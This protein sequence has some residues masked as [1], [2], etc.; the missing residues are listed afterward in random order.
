MK[1]FCLTILWLFAFTGIFADFLAN[2]RDILQ[3]DQQGHWYFFPV[4]NVDSA[5]FSI[6][7]L[8][9][10]GPQN[11]DAQAMNA[12][13]PSFQKAHLLGTDLL[14]RDILSAMI[15]GARTSLQVG[16]LSL[17]IAGLIGLFIGGFAGYYGDVGFKISIPRCV[18]SILSF[19]FLL[20][21]LIVLQRQVLLGIKDELIADLFPEMLLNFVILFLLQLLVHFILLNLEK[22]FHWKSW[23]FP[24]DMY[25]SRLIEIVSSLPIL[26]LIIAFSA[27]LRPSIWNVIFIIGLTG[28]TSIARFTRSELLSIKKQDYI[29][30]AKSMGIKERRI[31]I[32]HALPN[33]LPSILVALSFA[34][35]GAIIAESTLSF[36]GVGLPPEKVSWGSVLSM[37]RQRPSAWWLTLFPALA[38][39]LLIFSC[40]YLG[41]YYSSYKTANYSG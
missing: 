20:I 34:L 27:I 40:N 24:L 25:L 35:A 32:V 41:K 22:M 39:F 38:I 17:F 33:A 26:F 12:Q 28:W 16:F 36:L 11:I 23:D 1:Y 10:Y 2:E 3:I 19:I 8:V 37:A 5:S 4:H 30:S 9:K 31:L 21:Y 18:L 29:L 7:P 14:G 6:Q 13:P 15:H